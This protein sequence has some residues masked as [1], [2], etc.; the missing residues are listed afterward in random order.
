[1]KLWFRTSAIFTAM[2]LA[3]LAFDYWRKE[4][5]RQHARFDCVQVGM[6]R[7]EVVTIMG[8]ARV[9][10]HDHREQGPH[11]SCSYVNT[12]RLRQRLCSYHFALD[13]DLR[14]VKKEVR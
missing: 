6:T 7:G 4:P 3:T 11:M 13:D 2:V 5:F 9:Y 1:M 8:D 10:F 14:V 12:L